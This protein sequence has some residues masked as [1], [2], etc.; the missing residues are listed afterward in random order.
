MKIFR[1]MRPY[2]LVKSYIRKLYWWWMNRKGIYQFTLAEDRSFT[3]SIDRGASEITNP[4]Y[5]FIGVNTVN[6]YSVNTLPNTVRE[7]VESIYNQKDLSREDAFDM[8]D[9]LDEKIK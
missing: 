4:N 7:L 8:A 6:I 3:K 5:D 1:I 2:Y 9:Y